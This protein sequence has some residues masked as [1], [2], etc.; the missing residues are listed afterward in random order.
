MADELRIPSPH[1]QIEFHFCR[2]IHCRNYAQPPEMTAKWRRIKGLG[3]YTL[4]GGKSSTVN[5]ICKLCRRPFPVKSNIALSE[6]IERCWQPFTNLKVA[7]PNSACQRTLSRHSRKR[8]LIAAFGSTNAGHP[9]YKCNSCGTTFSRT[10]RNP[11]GLRRE[12]LD[13]QIATLLVNKM[14]MRRICEVADVSP[15]VLYNQVTRCHDLAMAFAARAE[16]SLMNT[17]QL[18]RVYLAIDRQDHVFNWGS[19]FDRRNTL[20]HVIASSDNETGYVFATHMNFD[21]DLEPVERDA[22]L[23]GDYE[24]PYHFRK[25]A[26]VWLQREYND[27]Y[28]TLRREA[29]RVKGKSLKADIM[30][31][32]RE[33]GEK[34][35]NNEDIKLPSQGM[36]VHSEYTL[37]AHFW[38]LARLLKQVEKIRIFMDQDSGMRS[39]C[40]GAFSAR[41]KDKTVEAFFVKIK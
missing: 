25:Y 13:I 15:S 5:L 32:Y 24:K 26:R 35:P 22:V 1:K 12:G 14:P 39:A 38:F 21:S 6:E 17:L 36:Q 18:R 3:A 23:S 31:G 16:E 10:K 40:L 11:R 28:H 20:L 27:E 2:N 37:Y 29:K 7:C 34:S 33:T 8:V 4:S 30:D 41:I 19:S 9:R